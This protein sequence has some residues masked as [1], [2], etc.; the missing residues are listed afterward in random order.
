M[1]HAHQLITRREFVAGSSVAAATLIASRSVVG[2]DVA[3]PFQAMGT[4]AGEVTDTTA[5]VWTRLTAA[6]T[7]N[8]GGVVIPKR[9]KDE[10]KRGK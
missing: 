10:A 6:R 5:I 4:R 3:G 1:K 9:T 2:A 7:R 8:N